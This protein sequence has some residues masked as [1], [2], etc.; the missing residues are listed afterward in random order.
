MTYKHKQVN[1]HANSQLYIRTSL[2]WNPSTHSHREVD[3][4]Y[5]TPECGGGVQGEN[6]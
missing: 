3:L 4:T 2:L 1:D 5:G 6:A